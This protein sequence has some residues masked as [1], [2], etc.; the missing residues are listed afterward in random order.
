MPSLNIMIMYVT[1]G[2]LCRWGSSTTKF[3][4][5]NTEIRRHYGDWGAGSSSSGQQFSFFI[6][7]PT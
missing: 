4:L 1:N 2:G 3:E 7:P 6:T 5:V